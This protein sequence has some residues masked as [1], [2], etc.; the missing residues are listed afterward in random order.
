MNKSVAAELLADD[1]TFA[2]V[3]HIIA[4]STY[5]DDMYG[6][7][8]LEL[9][10]NLED[11][12]KTELS[13]D[14]CQKLQA[15]V[16]ATTTDA[17]FQ[18]KEAFRAIC[19]TLIEGDPGFMIMDELTVIEILWSTYEVSLNHPGTDFSASVQGLMD[20]ELQEEGVDSE[21]EA[22][23]M[24]YYDRAM[25]SLTLKFKKQLI[26]LGL[27]ATALPKAA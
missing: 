24:P 18:D 16:L 27:D 1:S 6:M 11:D 8:I 14:V 25:D 10:Q 2:T 5:G 15:I 23:D 13:Q 3:A 20:R 9:F 19:N 7:D 4:Y 17:F 12:Y 22:E 21:E 26:K